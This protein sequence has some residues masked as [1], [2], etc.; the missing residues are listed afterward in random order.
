MKSRTETRMQMPTLLVA[1]VL[2]LGRSLP[3]W[4][5]ET[6]SVLNGVVKDASGAVIAGGTV[7]ITNK[8]TGRVYTT[9]T[10]MD[11]AYF[12]RDLEPGHYSVRF[13]MTGFAPVE[14]AD[15]NLLLGKTLKVDGTLQ[16]APVAQAVTIIET[17][18]SIDLSSTTIGHNVTSEEFL[19]LPKGRTFQGL[20]LTSPS[21]NSGII[22]GGFQVNGASGA[23]NQFVIDGV[24][25]NSQMDGRSRQNAVFEFLQEV[26]VKTGGIS[27]EYGGALGGVLSAVTKSGGNSFHGDVHYYFDGNE[28]AAGPVKRLL[29]VSETLSNKVN[30]FYSQ[31]DKQVLNRH[32]WGGSLGGPFMKDKMWFFVGVSPRWTR[33]ENDYILV[34]GTSRDSIRQKRFDQ[35]LFTKLSF[36]PVSRIRTN[37]SWLWT[38]TNST[39]RLPAYSF[40]P[41]GTTNN[42]TAFNRL[43][44][45][46]FRQP[47]SNYTGRIDF[48]LRN[49]MLLSVK[50]GRFWDNFKESGIAR[51]SAV[52][53]RTPTSELLNLEAQ[54]PA[55]QRGPSGFVNTPRLQFTDHD[56]AT[57]TFINADFGVFGHLWGDHDLKIGVGTTKNVNN[58]DNSYPGGGYVF[59]WWGRS[60]QSTVPGTPCALPNPPCSGAYGYYEVDDVGTKGTTGSNRTDLYITDSWRIHPRLILTLGLRAEKER[61]PSFRRDIQDF[62]FDF[63]FSDKLM[64]RVGFAYDVLGNGNLKASFA[65]GRFSDWVKYE[66]VRGTFGADV[67]RIRYRS[68]DTSNAFSLSGTNLPGRDLWN[69]AIPDSFRDNRIPAFD[70]IDPNIKPLSEDSLNATVE[71]QWGPR[72]VFRGSYVHTGLRRTIEDMGYVDPT[73]G[74]IRYL[75]GNPGEGLFKNALISTAT[76]AFRMPKPIRTYNAMELSIQRRF[77]NGWFANAS[78]VLSRLYGNYAGLASSD[79][80]RTPAFPGSYPVTQQQGGGTARAGSSSNLAFDLDEMLFDSHGHLNVKGP[81]PTDRTHV[82]KLY[83]SYTFRFGTEV[84]TFFS[85]GSGTPLSTQIYTTQDEEPFPEGRGDLGRTPIKTQTDLQV[86]HTW[87]VREG[88]QLRFEFNMLN[89]FNQKTALHRY[90][91]YNYWRTPS[92]AIELGNQNLAKGYDYKTLIG[93]KCPPAP[94]P[95]VNCTSD[96]P[97]AVDPRYKKDDLFNDG[98][99]ARFGLKFTF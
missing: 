34:D 82:F 14:V 68:L 9:T 43:K 49:D 62:A 95:S 83:G 28:I 59:A 85:G 50:A 55:E 77:A 30:G 92:S 76:P 1:I 16:V 74:D 60:F 65:W 56:L 11:G 51:V 81:L 27:A 97:N 73:T 44:D 25:T 19:R 37:F 18:P 32:E 94:A 48:T 88:K 3:L 93:T 20:L 31:D 7:T 79:E 13:Q 66:L 10:G 69:P 26:Q 98:F 58:V 91:Y 52:E 45:G 4:A 84:G 24:S 90:V 75:Y 71:Y 29:T 2:L 40:G 38:P 86:S 6:G 72:V 96:G 80:I 17:A 54:V 47:Q 64:P 23:E 35:N 89:L 67:W 39:G 36:D 5:Q 57:R 78:Y 8:A 46:G 63:P 33:R 61:V 22:E 53:Y 15:V 70:S 21:V 12:A 99:Q 41:N 42:Q 87:N